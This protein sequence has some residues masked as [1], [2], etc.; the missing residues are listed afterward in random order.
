[1]STAISCTRAAVPR[2]TPTAARCRRFASTEMVSSDAATAPILSSPRSKPYRESLNVTM[3][4]RVYPHLYKKTNEGEWRANERV[5]APYV[6]RPL[7]K[8]MGAKWAPIM[9]QEGVQRGL[10][11]YT[12]SNLT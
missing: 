12:S 2:V 10:S 5:S 6:R 1:M 4:R 3:H 11:A 7:P 8:K 9:R